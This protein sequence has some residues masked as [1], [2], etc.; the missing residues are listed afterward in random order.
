MIQVQ[1]ASTVHAEGVSGVRWVLV[2]P[3]DGRSDGAHAPTASAAAQ[4]T[5]NHGGTVRRTPLT[6]RVITAVVLVSALA[7]AWWV[8]SVVMG[9]GS[10]TRTMA[11]APR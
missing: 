1:I 4:P 6:L 7:G 3:S 11:V 9:P 2:D 5:V 10:A 8:A